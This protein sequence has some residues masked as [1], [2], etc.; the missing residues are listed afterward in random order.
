M[1][2]DCNH[3]SWG[4]VSKTGSH[5]SFCM[6]K[7]QGSDI[8][9]RCDSKGNLAFGTCHKCGFD[10]A[11]GRCRI[12]LPHY[13]CCEGVWVILSWDEE[14]SWIYGDGLWPVDVLKKRYTREESGEAYRK[15]VLSV[16]SEGAF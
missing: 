11:G 2:F 3:C 10:L 12:I 7:P 6:S 13:V 14:V 5:Y 9:C 8:L 16:M 15:Y 1:K 4:I